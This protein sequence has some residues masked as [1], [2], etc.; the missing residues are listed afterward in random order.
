M[1]EELMA[2]GKQLIK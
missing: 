2:H 1:S